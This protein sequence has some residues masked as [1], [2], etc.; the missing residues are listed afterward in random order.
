MRHHRRRE[1]MVDE[2]GLTLAEIAVAVAVVAVGLIGVAVV[3]PLASRGI[4]DGDQVSTATF[5]AEQMIERARAAAWTREPAVDCLGISAGDAAPRPS[6]GT[7]RGSVAT[8]FPDEPE[9]A[10]H[11]GYRRTV[12]VSDC[13][14]GAGCAGVAGEGLRRVTVAVSF[15]PLIVSGDVAP[16]LRTI[17]L[18]WLAGRQ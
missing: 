13:A 11:P 8:R 2:R 6:E 18:D 15:T 7:C 1:R 10:G 9:V 16:G 4:H 5:L 17:E 14:A 12:R 3:V